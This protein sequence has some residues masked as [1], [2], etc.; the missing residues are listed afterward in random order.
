MTPLANRFSQMLMM[1]LLVLATLAPAH[2]ESGREDVAGLVRSLGYGAAIHNFKNYVLRGQPEQYANA[3]RSFSDAQQHLNSLEKRPAIERQD[4]QDIAAL[5]A[6]ISAYSSGLELVGK[7]R[8]KGWRLEDVDRAVTVDDDDAIA[9]LDRLRAKWQWSELEQIEYQLGY[10][11][12]IHNFKNYL[13]RQQDRYHTSALENF[14]TTESLIVNQFN[15]AQLDKQQRAALEKIARVA[16][17][18]RNYLSLIERFHSMQRTERQIDLAV[19]VN[20]GPALM[21]LTLLNR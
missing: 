8:T 5:R 20:D 12:G 9:A 18:Y 19:K 10:G 3:R 2:A 15:S 4:Q 14:L 7:L 13:L 17:S 16:Q 6:M 21:A 1:A 11:K